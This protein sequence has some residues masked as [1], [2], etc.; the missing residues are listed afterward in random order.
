MISISGSSSVPILLP[1]AGP[2]SGGF[3]GVQLGVPGVG[4]EGFAA[5]ADLD[6]GGM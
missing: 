5:G 4:R 2:K 1:D 6:V 3:V